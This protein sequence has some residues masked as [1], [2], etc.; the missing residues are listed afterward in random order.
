[1]HSNSV[2]GV[3]RRTCNLKWVTSSIIPLGARCGFSPVL[4]GFAPPAHTKYI[5]VIFINSFSTT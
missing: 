2:V 4:Q 5:R 1:M 3:E